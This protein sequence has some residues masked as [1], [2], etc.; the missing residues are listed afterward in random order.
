[1]E[2]MGENQLRIL[3]V[4]CI[5]TEHLDYFTGA[6]FGWDYA[7][8]TKIKAWDIAERLTKLGLEFFTEFRPQATEKKWTA[9]FAI[10]KETI[11]IKESGM[12]DSM[13]EAVARAALKAHKRGITTSGGTNG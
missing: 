12:G 11:T 10:D 6:I 5:P 2:K 7:V 3:D 9:W 1:M 4:D 13:E 8:D